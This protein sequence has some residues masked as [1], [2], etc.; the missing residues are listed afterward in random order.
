[1]PSASELLQT[2]AAYAAARLA[3][4]DTVEVSERARMTYTDGQQTY[5]WNEYRAALLQQIKDTGAA[6]ESLAKAAQIVAGPF[7]VTTGTV[8][9]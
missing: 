4:L 5:G 7:T 9:G 6:V 3:E 8:R 1:V 2:A